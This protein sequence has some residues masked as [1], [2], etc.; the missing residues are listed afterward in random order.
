MNFKLKHTLPA[1][2]AAAMTFSHGAARAADQA[3]VDAAKKEGEVVWYSTLIINQIVRPMAD[4]FTKKYGIKV[5]YSRSP[6]GEV[7][8]KLT[9]EHRA[10]KLQADV[11]D[12]TAVIYTMLPN[13]M[14]GKIPAETTKD[15]PADYKDPDGRWAAMNLFF[16]TSAINTDLVKPADAPKTYEDLLNPKWS[17]KMAWT[18][19]PTVNG[20]PGFI[21]NVL[22]SMGKEKGMAYLKKLA[23]QKIVNVPSS[24]RVV[25]DQ[26]I[27]GQY[28]IGLMTFNHHSVIS[29][30]QGA[31]VQWLKMEP[32]TAT[33][34]YMSLLKAAP[35]PN[36]AKLF[37]DF[38]LSEEGQN[39]LREADYIPASPKV[40]AKNPELKP[41]AG[42]FKAVALVPQITNT[43]L[44]NW[45]KIYDELF[46]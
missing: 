3:L 18:T 44:P 16:L 38:V 14:L 29:G 5:S 21:G 1:L 6:A 37:A 36:A 8:L 30:A 15:Y 9:N 20:A 22:L 33:M 42:K 45:V 46:K 23:A 41:E 34:N 26:V 35:H 10:G 13:E 17:G 11:F 40:S 27:S 24:Q 32:L 25:L 12:A 28:P 19:D 7:A 4:A 39:V 2:I 31:P 43:E